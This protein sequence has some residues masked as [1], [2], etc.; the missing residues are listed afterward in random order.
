MIDDIITDSNVSTLTYTL[1]SG[2]YKTLSLNIEL[3]QGPV[4]E[5]NA[6]KMQWQ[7]H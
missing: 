4:Q 5:K 2:G 3:N 6:E 1:M 7:L